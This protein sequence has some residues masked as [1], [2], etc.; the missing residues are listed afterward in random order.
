[1]GFGR[2][3]GTQDQ[4]QRSVYAGQK[5]LER[6]KCVGVSLYA[7]LLASSWS[8]CSKLHLRFLNTSAARRQ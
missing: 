8:C 7:L 1:M 4:I 6:E 3:T 2:E 5:G